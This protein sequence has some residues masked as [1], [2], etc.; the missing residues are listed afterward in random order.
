VLFLR[1]PKK[2]I[3]LMGFDCYIAPQLLCSGISRR[4]EEYRQSGTLFEFPAER[5]F[6]TTGANNK[7]PH[8]FDAPT[9]KKAFES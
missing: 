3:D 4:T 5:M 8:P 1:K 7:N 9:L 2:F 6:P